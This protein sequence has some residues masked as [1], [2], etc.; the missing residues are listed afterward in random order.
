MSRTCHNCMYSVCDQE[1]WLRWLD[2]GLTIV[3]QCA[4]HPRWPGVLHDVP[5]VPC[6]HYEPKHP[7][8]TSDRVRWIPLGNGSYACV[9]AADYDW[10]RQ[11]EWHTYEG[12]YAARCENGK[13]IFM[14]RQIMQAP[15]G[16]VVDHSDGNRAN[17]CRSNLRVCTRE[18]NMR[19]IR[20][21]SGSSSRFKGVGW[22]R[23]SRKWYARIW[24]MGKRIRLGYFTDEAAAARA[25]D[26]KAV[27]LFGPY[28]RVNFPREWPPERRAEVYV[29][30]PPEAPKPPGRKKT[31]RQKAPKAAA[32]KKSATTRRRRTKA[33]ART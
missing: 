30:R 8:P 12:G 7:I 29:P 32:R 10:L 2:E 13:R 3:P 28:A 14:H 16:A 26:R 22:M 24:Y 18:E 11:W 21:H 33:G 23:Q 1:L 20:K 31:A 19:N 15:K 27:E 5:G 9:D 6:E 4:N 25:Y 17:N